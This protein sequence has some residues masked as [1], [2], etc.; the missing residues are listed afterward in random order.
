MLS[1]SIVSIEDLFPVP[2]WFS[3]LYS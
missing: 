1:Y 3:S 2:A